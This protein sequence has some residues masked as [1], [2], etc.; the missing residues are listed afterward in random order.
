[1]V[2]EQVCQTWNNLSHWNFHSPQVNWTTGPRLK[3]KTRG[4]TWISSRS[5]GVVNISAAPSHRG[6][7]EITDPLRPIRLRTVI[8]LNTGLSNP[9]TRGLCQTWLTMAFSGCSVGF[10]ESRVTGSIT[11][12]CDLTW[13]RFESPRCL[14]RSR[15][16]Y[17]LVIPL[18]ETL[19]N[20]SQ[21]PIL[22]GVDTIQR[23]F[24]HGWMYFPP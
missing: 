15:R 16:S 11:V 10:L 18:R 6:G 22:T 7:F 20:G 1:M 2:R 21:E 19:V 13:H 14:T 9:R 8:G 5:S 17:N 24:I 12:N 23:D 3:L 4:I